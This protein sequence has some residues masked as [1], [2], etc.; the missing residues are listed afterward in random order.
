[1]LACLPGKGD[2]IVSAIKLRRR[3][4]TGLLAVLFAV[5]LA[6]IIA[7]LV[8]APAAKGDPIDPVPTVAVS[9]PSSAMIG[10]SVSFDVSFVNDSATATGFGPFIDL[11]LP[12]GHDG[13]DGLTFASA[14]YLTSPL[15]VDVR[16]ADVN[17]NLTHP[18]A[19]DSNG[20]PVVIQHLQPYQTMV[21]LRMPFGSFTPGQPA[22]VAHVTVNLSDH[23]NVGWPLEIDAVGGFQ[24]GR[25]ALND[26]T[27][28][29]PTIF[30]ASD[31]A[32][33]TPTIMT[34]TKTF[35]GPT[36]VSAES[37]TGPDFPLSY[38][39][40]VTV[41]PGQTVDA[42][43][44]TDALPDSIEYL[45]TDNPD[46]FASIN[47]PTA[48]TT[49]GNLVIDFGTIGPVANTAS[50]TFHFIV[51][52]VDSSSAAILDPTSGAAATSTD[53]ASA[54]GLW[55]PID[56]LDRDPDGPTTV[57]AGPATHTFAD[58]AISIQ[59][60]VRKIGGGEVGPDDILEW[61]IDLQV[62]D[63]FALNNVSVSDLLSDGSRFDTN[64][65]PT[66]SVDGNPY[67]LTADGMN[68]ANFDESLNPDGTTAIEFRVSDEIDTRGENGRLVGGCIDAGGSDTPDCTLNHDG[69]TTAQIVF[70]TVVQR[71]YIDGKQVVEGD[72]LTNVASAFADV[73]DTKTFL[74]T[75]GHPSDGRADFSPAGASAQIS[76]AR[77]VLSKSIYAINGST[78]FT[79][80]V[81]IS[82]GDRV[83]YRLKQEFPASRTDDFSITDYLPLPIFAASTIAFSPVADATAPAA[84]KAK[85]GPDDTF[86]S[87]CSSDASSCPDAPPPAPSYDP[88]A[89]SIT[90][91]YGNY[92]L[93]PAKSS[94]ADILF[95][96]TVSTKPFADGLLLTNQARSRT[97]NSAGQVVTADAIVQVTLDQPVLAITKG[98]VGSDNSHAIYTP[99]SIGP[100]VFSGPTSVSCPTPS[101]PHITNAGLSADPVNS[102]VSGLDAGDLVRFAVVVQD[103]GHA[104]AFNVQLM[105]T[106]PQGFRKPDGGYAMCITDGGGN[107][108]TAT[109]ISDGQDIGDGEALFGTGIKLVDP[110]VGVSPNETV[111][112]ALA[113]GTSGST[114]NTAGTNIAVITY[115]L[116]VDT[117]A[118]PTAVSTNRAT[119]IDFTNSP[120]GTGHLAAALT[121]D[122]SATFSSPAIAKTITATGQNNGNSVVIG[123]KV[124]YQVT[125][126]VPEGTLPGARVVDTL[127]TGM[128]FAGCDSIATLSDGIATT[129]VTT[130]VAGGFDAVCSGASVVGQ[131]VTFD[132]GTLVNHNT[133]NSK[134]ET[135]V[136]TYEAVVLN[137]GDNHAGDT[138]QNAASF[139]WTGG[140]VGS[141]G[142]ASAD[143]VTVT[144]P[145]LS[146][147]K[148]SS[149]STGDAFDSI[150]YTITITN[151]SAGTDPNGA[152][153][154]DVVESDAIPAGMTYDGSTPFAE[155]PGGPAVSNLTVSGQTLSVT[156]DKI[157]QGET[158]VL[159]YHVKIDPDVVPSQTL[160]NVATLTW[161]SLPGDVPGERTGSASDPGGVLNDYTTSDGAEVD[162]PAVAAA[163]SIVATDQDSTSG[164]NV[165]VGEIVTYKVELTIPEGMAHNARLVDTLPAGMAFVRC[166]SGTPITASTGLT[167]DL[168]GGW[169]DACNGAAG[170]N[171]AN[172]GH[173]VTFG[174]GNI[175]NADQ[176]NG[177]PEKIDITYEAV[178]L[179]TG[180]NI[181]GQTLQNGAVMYWEDTTP[182]TFNSNTA[183]ADAVTVVEPKMT[184]TKTA[185]KTTGDAGDTITFT[186]DI[187]NPNGGQANDAF[188]VNWADTVPAGLNYVGGSLKP[189]DLSCADAPTS[190]SDASQP[191]L[192]A[193]WTSFPK[194]GTCALTYD[195]TLANDVSSGS[196]YSNAAT[197]T[198]TSLPGVHNTLRDLSTYNDLASERTGNTGDPGGSANDY[199]QISSVTV[200]VNQPAPVKSVITTSESGTAGT[201]N[202]AV[203][204]IVRYR[205]YV[206]IPEGVTD[207]VSVRDTLTA[208]LRYLNDNSTTVAFVTNGAGMTSTTLDDSSLYVSGNQDWV[209]D[210]GNHPTY[211][212]P[213]GSI[214]AGTGYNPEFD[215]G[216]L[217]NAD[218][219]PDQELVVIEFNALVENVTG[220]QSGTP[221]T[222]KA[223][224][225]ADPPLPA[226]QTPVDLQ[227]SN[228]VSQTVVEPV[229]SMAKTITTH[230]VDAGDEIDY[231]ITIANASATAPAYDYHVTDTLPSALVAPPISISSSCGTSADVSA[232]NLV[233]LTIT[234][235]APSASCTVTIKATVVATEPA[236]ET[237]TNHSDGTFSSLPGSGTPNGNPG[238]ATGS[239]TPGAS[240]DANGE[241]NGQDGSTG[242]NDY[243]NSG[244]VG[245]TLAAPSIV[246]NAPDVPHAPI[247]QL[248]TFNLLVTLPE[249]TTRGLIVTDT[250]QD[251]LDFVSATPVTSG[252]LLSADFSGTF[253]TPNPTPSVTTPDGTHHAYAL[254]FGDTVVPADQDP[255]ND[256]FEIQVTA[257][258]TN[259]AGNQAGTVLWNSAKLTY[260]NVSTPVDVAAPSQQAVTVYEPDVRLTKTA[261]STTPYFGDTVTYTLTLSHG[262]GAYDIAAQDLVL[263]DTLPVA[264]GWTY[265]GS[266]NASGCADAV[267]V[268]DSVAGH[269]TATF[270][271]F[272]INHS[273][274]ITYQAT[275]GTKPNANLKDTYTN[276]AAATWTSLSGSSS[277]ER[278]GNIAD[279]GGALN[280][281]K[282][283]AT[284]IVTVTG[285][286]L[287]IKKDDIAA[288][289]IDKQVLRYKVSFQNNGNVNATGVVITETVPIG[290]K[291]DSADSTGT[292]TGCV[293]NSSAG[294]VCHL[295]Y[296]TVRPIPLDNNL[297]YYFAVTVVD[298]IAAGLTQIVNTATIADD[299]THHADATPSDNTSTDTD[300]IPQAD[301]SLTK[302]VD[303]ARPGKNQDVTYTITLHND[304]PDPATT[305]KVTDLVP[306]QLTYKSSV[307]GSGN[308]YASG[309]GL[310]IIGGSIPSG[311]SKTLTITATASTSNVGVNAAQVTYSDDGDP[312]STPNNGVTTEDDYASATTT[313]L[314]A[315]IGVTKTVDNAHPDKGS[316]V[317]FTVT[318]T[319]HGPDDDPNVVVSDAIPSAVTPDTIT[320]SAGT[321]A[322]STWTVG[323]LANGASATLTVSGTVTTAGTVT[324]TATVTHA[325]GD[326]WDLVSSNDSA[327]A[328]ISQLVNIAVSKSVDVATPNVGDVVTFT[329]G[330]TNTETNT[331]NDV[332]IS[333]LLPAGLTLGTATP[334][335]GT[336]DSGTGHW[337]VG[338]IG[339]SGAASMTMTA[340]VVSGSARTN[341]AS[342]F[343]LD[344]TQTSL[345]DDSAS[346]TETPQNADLVV[347]KTVDNAN[348]E[349]GGTVNFTVTV[350]NSGPDT[351]TNVTMSDVLPAGLT[352]ISATP[353]QGSYD[354]ISGNWSIGTL[355]KNAVVTLQVAESVPAGGAWTNTAAVSHSDEFDPVAGNNSAEVTVTSRTADIGVTK[356]VDNATPTVGST[357]LY[358][359]TV[360][361]HGPTY[362]VT[363][364]LVR[365]KLPAGLAF[366]SASPSAGSYDAA[367]GDW[368]IGSLA[369]GSSVNMPITATV[370][371]SGSITNTLSFV[372]MLQ[373][374]SNS[375]N[376][377][378]SATIT[379]PAA[380]DLAVTKVEDTN[381]PDVGAKVNFTITATN[382]GPD[383]ATNVVVA[384][385]IPAGLTLDPVTPPAGTSWTGSAWNIGNLSNGATKNLTLTATVNTAG[386]RT[387][388]ATISGS[389]TDPVP[390]NNSSS[391]S[392]DQRVNIVVSKTVSNATP[393]VGDVVTFTVTVRNTGLNTANNVTISDALPAGLTLGVATP[394]QGSYNTSNHRW[395]VFTLAPSGSATMTMTATVASSGTLTNTAS[396]YHVDETQTS[397]LDDSASASET[398]AQADLRVQKSVDN[399]TPDI[400]NTVKFT[401]TVTNLGPD[402]ASNVSIHDALP[403]GLTFSSASATVGGYVSGTG[404]WTVGAML[405][406]ATATLTVNAV[407]ATGGS[408][409]NTASVAHSDQYDPV[410]GN[411]TASAGLTSHMA[412][413]GVAKTVSGSTT[414]N[415]GDNVTYLLTVT[416]NGP[417]G[418]TSLI[419]RDLIPA[420]LSFV[421]AAPSQG[422]YTAGTGNWSIGTLANGA[423]VTMTLVAKVT[424]SG[425][426]DNTVSFWSMLQT[427][428]N[429]A[430]NSAT[431]TVN[432]TAAADLA[433]TKTVNDT[434]PDVGDD[435][436]FTVTA[437]NNGPD[438]ATNVAVTDA[439]PA[440]LSLV[441]ATPPAGTSWAG[442]TWTIGNLAVGAGATET[443]TVVAHVGNAGL[444]TNT[445]TIAGAEHDPV[446][447][448]NTAGAAVDQRVHFVVTK[449]VSPVKPNVGS[450][451]TFTIHVSN[452]G[453][454]DAHNVVVNDTLPAGVTYVSDT[455]VGAYS[456]GVWTI[457]SIAS[458]SSASLDIV[459]RVDSPNA[460]TNTATVASASETQ[461]STGS[462]SDSATET[463]QQADLQVTKTVDKSKPELG[464]NVVFT[465][466]LRNNGPDDATN[467]LLSDVLPDNLTWVSDDG[468]GEY[469]HSTGVWD[470]GGLESDAA[471]TLHITAHV[472]AKGDYDNTATVTHS[473]QYDPNPDNNHSDAFLTTGSADIGVTKTVDHNKP[474]VGTVVTYT[475]TAINNGGDP[476]SGLVI[477]DVLAAGRLTFVSASATVGSYNSTSG[478]WSVGNLAVGSSAVL[479][480]QARVIDSGHIDNTAAVTALLQRDE[481]SGNDSATVGIDAPDAADLSLTKTVDND[482]PDKDATVV[483]TVTVSNA[484]PNNTSGV[485]VA[486]KL[487]ADLAYVSD[488]GGTVGS[489]PAYDAAT[490]LWTI[491]DLA[492]GAHATIHITATVSVGDTQIVNT[493]EVASS[494]LPDPDSTPNNGAAGE[495]D[496]DSV[497]L[498]AHGVA[499]LSIHKSI[500][501]STLHKG[502][503]ATYTIV[504]TNKGPQ[505]ATGV[506]VRD[507][508]PSA[509]TYIGA[510]GGT[511]DQH[512]GAWTV[513]NLA[514]GASATLHI[515]VSIGKTGAISNT[516]SVV[517]EDQRDPVSSNNQFTA[518]VSAAGPTPPVTVVND[519]GPLPHDPA[520]LILWLLA[521]AFGAIAL[522]G[523]TALAIRN[524]RLKMRL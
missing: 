504:I 185:S 10:S 373:T 243:V 469:D 174:L 233:D 219:D 468:G 20:D 101:D 473:D 432:V 289:A 166:I 47:E 332:V 285:V 102:D 182:T 399:S 367:S 56:P 124:S 242:L 512:T 261:S 410:A 173:D 210:P 428:S 100:V 382:N 449:T 71:T 2:S 8:G 164:D 139:S 137:S 93:Y 474:A 424:A 238:N 292:W 426:I 200:T 460:V 494:D 31:T 169:A 70:H 236:G 181:R 154:F 321:Y 192:S 319:N 475:V 28:D 501:P 361:N 491:G 148:D 103:T 162:V 414:P 343:S 523:A 62:S 356:T 392:L 14:T 444:I 119:L 86:H 246:K 203:G 89:N 209:T 358:T 507:Q 455:G 427:D 225:W 157:Q 517:A 135:V 253:T 58:R 217:N 335:H 459:V 462:D 204:E 128:G 81:H 122:A 190:Y 107:P 69:A 170:L 226:A 387:N 163:K 283:T 188:D 114:D 425:Q 254:S 445:A 302:T 457:P 379:V 443:L 220:N 396:V 377:T 45:S 78:S 369:N 397:T 189:A 490:G 212:L 407:V 365:D 9:A 506:I 284:R 326:P 435:V 363:S 401:V 63:F 509:V 376:N 348:P 97:S 183:R 198:W 275:I 447:S 364:L 316:S 482:T 400:G 355:A 144:E 105:D 221:L 72:T 215:L 205:V 244:Q 416:N 19:V 309:S 481:V 92:A 193:T 252:G 312:D 409:T 287:Y 334:D 419:V 333:D 44:V 199:K 180:T 257:R 138:L 115:T 375:A 344:E 320:P 456:G 487:P 371:A 41:A 431:A 349:I 239:S 201:T 255:A 286:D 46:Q 479:T 434:T 134:A 263:D 65:A 265:A 207:N 57:T 476:A 430:N 342:V 502:D 150:A 402:A 393:N 229:M 331:A 118:V 466:N 277:Y 143:P 87:M 496:L 247:G 303:V 315:D 421:S 206:A 311:G 453:P 520:T 145:Q 54:T 386:A 96:V 224:I 18:Y 306:P 172:N 384:D 374:D 155:D 350:T 149:V 328:T 38:T 11:T 336:Y 437:R 230:P 142:P 250:L 129:D 340:T 108:I 524:N 329:V 510:T 484:G 471:A 75:G 403:V 127:P 77:G 116:Q 165:V 295:S 25:T 88:V 42:V 493:A 485:T 60:S 167:T 59:K 341:T 218:R 446:S 55:T 411:N 405:N 398:S 241:R 317:T 227:D 408:Y 495:D 61:T 477:G 168:S 480:L 282:A 161:T 415:V 147:Q 176:D 21:I 260:T 232:D 385:P 359:L 4:G 80:P 6:P 95:T 15:A 360:T 422:S 338:S 49:G 308:S 307:A 279:L 461:S 325:I 511:Y 362:G 171:V 136:I 404:T 441:L 296:A 450:N 276:N 29:D 184:V 352:Y 141:V 467:I 197:L 37:A 196:S 463:P 492:K 132:M 194:G 288:T 370:T 488:D 160:P 249:G 74:P 43:T 73:L 22:A 368:T 258:V 104:A 3:L 389:Q 381:R 123:E 13:N 436:T 297:S 372:S 177:T 109:N 322:G 489:D 465:I 313:P 452:T 383:D 354:H 499:D 470:V 48:G 240:G 300:A 248:T 273:C 274:V 228:T 378:A 76:I 388:T 478:A 113:A 245:Q 27:D 291:F 497:T 366:V 84:D 417:D 91:T 327:G 438:A 451:T 64:F 234:E 214:V 30:G 281:Y 130:D 454:N 299:G 51:P 472:A 35:H 513:G 40:T 90:F 357:V 486:D 223:A 110:T 483:F 522:L 440:G 293:N 94:V 208:G 66:L 140:Q 216:N 294:T 213:S 498:N 111:V 158:A 106:I 314:I 83:T 391:V 271:T 500:S 448:N 347:A 5:A 131:N 345:L 153:A 505:N 152:T 146:I 412:D 423:N 202:L 519:S 433:V 298:P 318:V 186:V 394:S 270:N 272:P 175:T 82:P 156:W 26:P 187:A 79:T 380:A 323:A 390:G 33:V 264:A 99:A 406:G 458:G 98:V 34:V 235:V 395:T 418:A 266:L 12:L 1:M 256:K 305:V 126:T 268:S 23:A 503:H 39:L 191:N 515:T 117:S 267:T 159:H 330:V 36:N 231:V 439:L 251:G 120:T 67:T 24:F 151:P 17:G 304:G 429:S 413:I 301:L 351:A 337:S 53:S 290:T 7:T 179:N 16:T 52:R 269:I 516:A 125:L 121:D 262:N 195:A 346:A 420:G 211:V 112:G 521:I 518:G 353:S 85:Y 32:D 324:N 339:P 259:V 508:L 514:N 178:V 464:D 68:S 133:D 222:D 310:W 50:A 442:D 278:T 280:D 237:F